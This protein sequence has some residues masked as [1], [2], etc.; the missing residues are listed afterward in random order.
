MGEVVIMKTGIS[1]Q[2]QAP[3]GRHRRNPEQLMMNMKIRKPK[4]QRPQAQT[5]TIQENTTYSKTGKHRKASHA[6]QI[7][8]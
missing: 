5:N 4:G 3:S 1:N 7:T 2:L 6:V 8:A